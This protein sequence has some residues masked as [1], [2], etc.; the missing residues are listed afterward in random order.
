MDDV[1]TSG[2]MRWA[3]DPVTGKSVLVK[4]MTYAEWAGW[5]EKSVSVFDSVPVNYRDK[6][7]QH[8]NSAPPEI[9]NAWEKCAD[10]LHAPK[11]D[12]N[13]G[14]YFTQQDQCT[15]FASM[16][17]AYEASNID[18][19]NG[20]FFHEFGHNIDYIL[21]GGD[22][23]KIISD[24]YS[25]QYK[26]NIFG[27]TIDK[28]CESLYKNFWYSLNGKDAVYHSV[29][30][31]QNGYGGMGFDQ[32]LKSAIRQKLPRKEYRKVR[33]IIE[34]A[35]GKDEILRP[36]FD[37][38]LLSYEENNIIY[39]DKKSAKQFCDSVKA[40]F[41]L[42]ERADVSD[43]FEKFTVDNFDIQYPFGAGHGKAY[44]RGAN[45]TEKEAFAEMFSA[46]AIN[47][48]SLNVIKQIFPE[49]YKI[50]ID[51]LKEV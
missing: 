19:E 47:S 14:A 24:F 22:G 50:F 45:A 31:G 29:K 11:Y 30:D 7:M 49:S 1:D 12:I 13:S 3:R 43:M 35:N 48:K 36:I 17:M 42:H 5:K 32:Y 38:Y 40:Q 41:D 51:M 39:S 33:D 21:A 2:G 23:S 26:D 37:K 16:K 20:V 4:D 44:T 27:K 25:T 6:V 9:R 46:T 15:H 8:Y 10:K 28:E 18:E 34:A